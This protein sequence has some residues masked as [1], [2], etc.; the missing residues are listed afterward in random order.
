MCS[1]GDD[2]HRRKRRVELPGGR[3]I[4]FVDSGGSGPALL[5]LHGYS[6][7]GRSFA[8]LEPF[9]SGYR[10]IIPDLPG[11]GASALGEGMHVSDFAVSIDR[12]L[13]FLGV[14]QFALI[15][16]SMGAMT[17]I[18]LAARRCDDVS[19]LVLLSASLRPDF[20]GGSPLSREIRALRDPID[21]SGQF[22]RDWYSCSR[23]VAAEF[24]SKMR[25][26]AA[27]MPAAV[28]HGILQGF[29]E[30]DLRYSARQV[31]APVLCIGGSADPL[32]AGPHREAL[33]QAFRSVRSVTLD[34]YGH[35]PHWEDP[36]RVSALM[37]SF[38]A[39]AGM[40]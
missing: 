19:A 3:H 15:G 24:L 23:P 10:L 5:L 38:F 27:G 18:E 30:T 26:D 32:F 6:D 22:L 34:G 31:A 8:S 12:F 39:E 17:A 1:V 2:W 28:W 29:A 25:M 11:H 7:T 20:G 36:Q 13:A 37:I 14:S 21:P 9:L 16:H 35:N 40:V 33:A 4:A